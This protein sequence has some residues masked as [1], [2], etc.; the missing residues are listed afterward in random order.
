MLQNITDGISALMFPLLEHSSGVASRNESFI[1]TEICNS[2]HLRPL[3]AFHFTLR[4]FV[5]AQ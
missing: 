5:T 2:T 3:V 1:E 4:L